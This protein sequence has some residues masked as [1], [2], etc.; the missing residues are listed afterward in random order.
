MKNASALAPPMLSVSV[1][2]STPRA[3]ACHARAYIPWKYC[4]FAVTAVTLLSSKTKATDRKS[5]A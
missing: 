3:R 4:F 2:W 5:I 1:S